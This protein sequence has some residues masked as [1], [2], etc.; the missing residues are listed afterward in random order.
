MSHESQKGQKDSYIGKPKGGVS[1]PNIIR[2]GK[3]PKNLRSGPQT[4][5]KRL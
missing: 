5:P 3:I 1:N 4:V 2:E